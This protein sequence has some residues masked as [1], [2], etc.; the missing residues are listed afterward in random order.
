LKRSVAGFGNEI[1]NEA[2]EGV[3]G[4][5]DLAEI[6]GAKDGLF[7]DVAKEYRSVDKV[8]A[9]LKEWKSAYT[10]DFERTYTS[11]SLPSA[12]ALH[13]KQELIGWDPFATKVGCHRF[14]N[15]RQ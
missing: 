7:E 11:L 8:L 5:S 3:D 4:D 9:F 13:V 14:Y 10:S 2:E 12:V 6:M 15:L 1:Q